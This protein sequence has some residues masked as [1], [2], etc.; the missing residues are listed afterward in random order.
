MNFLIIE[1]AMRTITVEPDFGHHAANDDCFTLTKHANQRMSQRGIHLKQVLGVLKYGRI[2]HSRRARFYVLGKRDVDDLAKQCID[3][4]D[5]ENIQVLVDEKSNVI[6]TAYKN[7]N[8]RQIRPKHRH[9][10]RM[11]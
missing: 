1:S 8:F 4:R 2:I 5:I 7:K 9:E 6:L 3:V 11:N 10:R